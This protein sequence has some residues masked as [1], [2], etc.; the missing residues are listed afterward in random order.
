MERNKGLAGSKPNGLFS[1]HPDTQARM[2]KQNKQIKAEKLAGTAMGQ[3]RYAAHV[4][5]DATP[6]T[7]ITLTSSEAKGVAGASSS[8]SSAKA[9]QK[10][11]AKEAKKGGMFGGLGSALSTG[12]QKEGDAGVGLGRRPRARPQPSGPLRRRRGKSQQTE[13][14]GDSRRDR[15]I[16]EGHRLTGCATGR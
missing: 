15:G 11:P 3:A 2:D 9:E 5:Y 16:Q 1:T 10:P 13:R 12:K 8:G 7:A 4:K 6:R 14:D